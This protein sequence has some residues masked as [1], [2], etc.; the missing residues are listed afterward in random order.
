M[1][2]KQN[3]LVQSFYPLAAEVEP[4]IDFPHCL[5]CIL[6]GRKPYEKSLKFASN[7]GSMMIISAA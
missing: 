1:I 5:V 6:P 4:L 7:K 2:G 3:A